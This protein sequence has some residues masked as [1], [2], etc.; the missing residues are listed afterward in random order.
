[1][2]CDTCG[3]ATPDG[4]YNLVSWTRSKL[5]DW[6]VADR[7]QIDWHGHDD[8]GMSLI[9][10]LYAVSA[11]ADRVHGTVRGVG[12]R[13]GN[14]PLELLILNLKL[15]REDFA[16]VPALN[17]ITQLVAEAVGMDI[18]VDFPA[19]GK[20]AF[21]TATGVHAAAIVK[22]L[23]RGDTWLADLVYSAVPATMVGRTQHIEVG[24][25]SGHSNVK[26]WLA[27]NGLTATNEQ[28]DAVFRAAKRCNST[29][30]DDDI[31]GILAQTAIAPPAEVLT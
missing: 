16:S 11:G 9:N 4:A 17:E 21:R 24:H 23:D 20:D 2:L 13:V 8:R 6:G 15:I 29:L 26:A 5:R 3:H 14:T 12:E 7:V 1:M 31:R 18:P 19:F 28:I 10:A 22:A 25:M 27:A 30:S